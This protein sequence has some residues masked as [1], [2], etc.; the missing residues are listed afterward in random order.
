MKK[1]L[2]MF[3][4]LALTSLVAFGADVNGKWMSEGGGKGGPQT[5][6][7]KA[8]GMKLSGTVETQRGSTEISNGKIDGDS[9]S[10]TTVRD[11]GDKGKMTTNY[12]GTVSGDT[13][14]LSAETEGMGKG[15]RE[16]TLKKSGT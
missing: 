12:K 7:F 8:D 2:G 6:T 10:F 14:K 4:L 15:P 1:V 9:I 5:Y 13:M 11:M 16:I 3:G